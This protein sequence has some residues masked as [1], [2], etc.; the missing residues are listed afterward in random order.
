M[1]VGT[2]ACCTH[3]PVH[4]SLLLNS[5]CGWSCISSCYLLSYIL[6]HS[7]NSC[8][9]CIVWMCCRCMAAC[10]SSF[11]L[12]ELCLLATR[13][14]KWANKPSEVSETHA[15]EA[16]QFT[17]TRNIANNTPCDWSWLSDQKKQNVVY[18]KYDSGCINYSFT[19][20]GNSPQCVICSYALSNSAIFPIRTNRHFDKNAVSIKI[21]GQIFQEKRNLNARR[22]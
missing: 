2:L 1:K 21:I 19:C 11:T 13:W 20:T 4:S 14:T 12:I 8:G 15:E 22:D 9:T 6:K 17:S 3:T 5:Y 10:E 7:V 16:I 18:W